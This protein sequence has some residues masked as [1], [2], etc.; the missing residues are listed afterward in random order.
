ML[1]CLS[2]VKLQS[3]PRPAPGQAP[4]YSGALDAT[5]QVLRTMLNFP[6][7]YIRSLIAGNG[8]A[9]CRNGSRAIDKVTAAMKLS[10]QQEL[11]P[12]RH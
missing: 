9:A 12:C 10:V 8:A 11:W 4:Q 2:Q 5:K 7:Y 1:V 3:Q 6:I